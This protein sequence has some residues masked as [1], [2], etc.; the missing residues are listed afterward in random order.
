MKICAASE[1][2]ELCDSR[3]GCIAIQAQLSSR[4]FL[5]EVTDPH[6]QN[7]YTLRVKRLQLPVTV[8]TASTIHTLQGT[9][10]SPGLIFHWKYPRFFSEELRWLATYVALSRPPSLEQLISIDMPEGLK[11]IIEGGP[12]AGILTRFKDMFDEKEEF[13]HRK[14]EE[15]LKK[16]GWD[17]D[18]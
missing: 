6:T 12:P 13:T 4:A 14:A 1:E 8:R 18:E 2:C 16:L 3:S 15:V 17:L 5:V 10:A 9:T 7:I 11:K